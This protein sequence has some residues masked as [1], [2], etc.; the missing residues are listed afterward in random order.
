MKSGESFLPKTWILEK[1]IDGDIYQPWQYFTLDTNACATRYENSLCMKQYV[2]SMRLKYG[3]IKYLIMS[4]DSDTHNNF[5]LARYIRLRFQGAIKH[6][7]EIIQERIAKWTPD[8]DD[9][10][11]RTYY[12]IQ[13][14]FIIG[15]CYCS[16]H[17]AK[18]RENSDTKMPQC[19]CMHNAC[20]KSCEKCCPMYNQRPYKVGTP[21]Q[22]NRCE[23]CQ[24]FGH[25]TSCRYSA[26]IDARNLSRNVKGKMSGGGVC[27]DCANFTTGINCEKCIGGY[28]RPFDRAPDH[29]TPCIPCEC[30]SKGSSGECNPY[31]GECVCKTGFTGIKCDKCAVGYGGDNCEKCMCSVQGTIPGA[32]CED[33]CQ[34]K[35]N[36]MGAACDKCKHGY[37]GLTFDNPDGCLKCYCSGLDASC[38]SHHV[39][40]K[41]IRDREGWTVTDISRSEVAYPIKNL[42]TG[43][44]VYDMSELSVEA[45]Y[46]SAPEA[47]LGNLL[48]HY[49]SR[50][51]FQVDFN[52]VRGDTSGKPTESPNFIMI[53][54]NG[55]KIAYG[56]GIFTNTN[57]SVD[58]ILNEKNWY[59]IPQDLNDIQTRLRRSEYRGDMVTRTQFMSVLTGVEAILLRGMYHT[60][61][62][63]AVLKRAILYSGDVST[64]NEVLD[65]DHDG[66]VSLVELCQCPPEYAGLSCERCKFGHIP[67]I[68]NT[69]TYDSVLRCMPCKCN[70]HSETCDIANNKCGE[71]IHNTRGERLVETHLR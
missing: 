26:D 67:V 15:R 55:M 3:E 11:T 33:T 24:C 8:N 37:F 51:I 39:T 9:L 20:G 14:I 43:L 46:W 18:C 48:E 19:E 6:P 13:S 68:G 22:D 12:S 41:R 40:K 10:L 34:C 35:P 2:E 31:G 50:F 61:Q 63:E 27:V 65:D 49:N 16:G 47:F 4:H 25:A 28:Y 30:N 38:A 56:D 32:E 29:E 58:V 44:Y 21:Q 54:N 36:V 59:H 52:L 53:G 62:D 17:A 5:T 64:F 1:S 60:D 66:V 42:E 57:A 23:K 70:G 69:S 71:C 7:A 45:I